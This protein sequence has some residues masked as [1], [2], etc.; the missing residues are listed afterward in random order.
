MPSGFRNERRHSRRIVGG[1]AAIDRAQVVATVSY[2]LTCPVIQ[3]SSIFSIAS[4]ERAELLC[5]FSDISC[6]VIDGKG[7]MIQI[8]HD[9]CGRLAFAGT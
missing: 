4:K 2:S 7:Q 3:I 9:L 8:L 6:S 1:I 5:D